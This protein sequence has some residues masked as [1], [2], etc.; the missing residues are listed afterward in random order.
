MTIPLSSKR[1]DG[2]NSTLIV[3]DSP[4]YRLRE[5]ET[6]DSLIHHGVVHFYYSDYENSLI[7][8]FHRTPVLGDVMSH[9]LLWAVSL[10]TAIKIIVFHRE[11][12]KLFINP[13]VGLFY[14]CLSR[15]LGINE[16]IGLAGLLFAPKSNGL[17]LRLRKEFTQFCCAKATVVFVYSQGELA[18]YSGIFPRIASKLKFILYGRDY[19][20]FSNK[21]FEG[22][23]NYIASGGISNRDFNTL[24]EALLILQADGFPVKC[25]IAT[26]RP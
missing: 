1:L 14:C 24:A 2:E 9:I 11:R 25:S 23:P 26:R 21:Q 19:D 6:R 12:T 3:D 7:R 15:I 16:D 4:K 10:F 17:Y 18:E 13:I 5:Q 8:L 20:V 22:S